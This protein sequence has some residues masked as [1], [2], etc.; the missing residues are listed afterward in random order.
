METAIGQIIKKVKDSK[1]MTNE[2]FVKILESF[3]PTEQKQIIDAFNEGVK[4]GNS[5]LQ[6]FD[7]PASRYF[8]FTYKQIKKN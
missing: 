5:D 1:D 7:Y 8:G 6:T 4:Y 2:N 3:L